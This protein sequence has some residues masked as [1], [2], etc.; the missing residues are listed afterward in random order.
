M[1]MSRFAGM[2]PRLRQERTVIAFS[3]MSRARSAAFGQMS[4]T[5]FMRCILYSHTPQ[6]NPFCTVHRAIYDTMEQH[7]RLRLA[8]TKA[9]F[10]TAADAA[11]RFGWQMETYRHH[12][13]GTRNAPKAKV[14]TYARAFRVSPEWLLLG[15]GDSSK[16]PLPLVGYVGAGAEVYAIDDGGCLDEIEPPPGIGPDAVAVLVRGD[17]MFP[18]YM[19]GDLLIYDAHVTLQKADGQECV[20]GLPDGRRFVKIVRAEKD[21]MAT[22]ESWNRPPMREVMIEWVAPVMWVRR[23]GTR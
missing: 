20:V 22:L 21:G 7:E 3:P 15:I 18:R 23:A 12:E 11:R 19:E 8:R 16:R 5:C 6:V 9:G 2:A 13:N 4:K 1:A 17:S 10:L 14:Q